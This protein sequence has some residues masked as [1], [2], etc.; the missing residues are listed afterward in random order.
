MEGFWS[1]TFFTVLAQASVGM[2]LF[3][4]CRNDVAPRSGILLSAFV[5][6]MGGLLA[7]V[8]HLSAPLHGPYA[9]TNFTTSWLSREIIGMSAF[10]GLLFLAF[11]TGNKALRTLTGIMGLILIYIMGGIY[12]RPTM[13][14]WGG[15]IVYATFLTTAFV[16]GAST[17]LFFRL[18]QQKDAKAMTEILRGPLALMLA[19]GILAR[20]IL[21]P[22]Q[23]INA[24]TNFSTTIFVIHLALIGLGA[25]FLLCLYVK[26]IKTL[27]G[28]SSCSAC[29]IP[30][31]LLMVLFLWAGEFLGRVLFFTLYTYF[32]A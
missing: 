24:G 28:A 15:W 2:A 9:L 27:S 11:L 18:R 3:S 4:M 22:L 30:T 29:F 8:T 14:Y 6:C 1:L 32:G 21:S 26:S 20:F 31:T 19:L 5:I 25:L 17:L 13:Y 23:V 16:L 7:S 10:S 12:T